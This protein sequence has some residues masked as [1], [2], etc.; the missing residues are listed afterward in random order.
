[1]REKERKEMEEEEKEQYT[2]ILTSTLCP[3]IPSGLM[4]C[5]VE[6]KIKEGSNSKVFLKNIKILHSKFYNY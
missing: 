1:M 5:K 6:L 3:L 4:I 2:N